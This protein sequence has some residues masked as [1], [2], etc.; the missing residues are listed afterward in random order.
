MAA[1]KRKRRS[2]ALGTGY[3]TEIRELRAA[4]MSEA[5]VLR[6]MPGLSPSELAIT[7]SLPSRRGRPPKE[8]TI[9][10]VAAV[11]RWRA[12]KRPRTVR[13]AV[14]CIDYLLSLIDAPKGR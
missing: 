8:P 12:T 13:A 2:R 5:D 1:I 9:T 3:R 14:E 6:H 7:L 4:G 10:S 11:R